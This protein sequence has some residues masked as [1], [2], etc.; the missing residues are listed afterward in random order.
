MQIPSC[1]SSVYHHCIDMG[2]TLEIDVS[3][4]EGERYMGPFCLDDWSGEG[5][6]IDPLIVVVLLPFCVELRAGFSGNHVNNPSKGL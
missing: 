1:Y 3:G 4:V 6:V 2:C 5:Y